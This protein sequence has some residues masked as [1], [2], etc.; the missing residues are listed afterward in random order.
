MEVPT[1]SNLNQIQDCPQVLE[2][3]GTTLHLYK[4][5]DI[6]GILY[7][8]PGTPID[9]AI[10][11]GNPQNKISGSFSSAMGETGEILIRQQSHHCVAVNIPPEVSKKPF[12]DWA[13]VCKVHC[14]ATHCPPNSLP[15]SCG[16]IIQFPVTQSLSLLGVTWW[17]HIPTSTNVILRPGRLW[18]PLWHTHTSAYLGVTSTRLTL[19][20]DILRF[21]I[22]THYPNSTQATA[23]RWSQ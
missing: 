13:K 4:G 23:L 11:F 15:C 7:F 18:E 8:I 19:Y 9:K 6:S 2:W 5:D 1:L 12:K 16:W 14:S 20:W 10:P 21:W 22:H 17:T 3:K